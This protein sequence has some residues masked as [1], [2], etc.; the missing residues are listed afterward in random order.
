MSVCLAVCEPVCVRVRVVAPLPL[1]AR[2]DVFKW[3]Q[4]F[5]VDRY[6]QVCVCLDGWVC[7]CVPVSGCVCVCAPV[8]G[9]V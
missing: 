9:C 7:L 8:S 4:Y 1:D 2:A 6:A 5:D 3:D